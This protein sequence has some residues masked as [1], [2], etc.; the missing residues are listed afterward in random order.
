MYVI[1]Y[2]IMHELTHLLETNHTPVFWNQ[3]AAQQPGYEKAREWLK[4]NGGELERDF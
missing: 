1:E 4:V 2:I 3:M